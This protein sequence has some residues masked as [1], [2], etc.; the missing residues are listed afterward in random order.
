MNSELYQ[1]M[2]NVPAIAQIIIVQATRRRAAGTITQA[3]F[4]EQMGR[5]IHE[6]LNP[7]GLVLVVRDLP[8]GRTRFLIKEVATGAV[9]DMM[10]FAQDGTLEMDPG[11]TDATESW[12]PTASAAAR[13]N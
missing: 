6:D 9:C 1:R 5:L 2:K 8:N 11:P 12:S 13:S 4:E 3:V 7:K 10:D